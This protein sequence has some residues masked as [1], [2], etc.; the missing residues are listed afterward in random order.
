MA[1]NIKDIKI[2]HNVALPPRTRRS[3]NY[4]ADPLYRA[5]M[6][7]EVGDSFALTVRN[8]KEGARIYTKVFYRVKN[9]KNKGM[10]PDDFKLARRTLDK[11]DGIEVRFYRVQ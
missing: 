10:L 2:E 6:E 7:M 1:L 4:D 8:R 11:E 3:K 9:A 5:L